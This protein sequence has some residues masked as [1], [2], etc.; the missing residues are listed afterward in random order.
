M[1]I[2]SFLSIIY[3]MPKLS[4]KPFKKTSD[5]KRKLHT[6]LKSPLA[7]SVDWRTRILE[8]EIK[9]RIVAVKEAAQRNA[10]ESVPDLIKALVQENRENSLNFEHETFEHEIRIAITN[11]RHSKEHLQL[12]CMMCK[13]ADNDERQVGAFVIGQWGEINCLELVIAGLEDKDSDV[14]LYSAEAIEY[15][16]KKGHNCQ[17]AKKSLFEARRRIGD[18]LLHE[19]IEDALVAIGVSRDEIAK[20]IKYVDLSI[21]TEQWGYAIMDL[22][23]GSLKSKVIKEL[24]KVN[25]QP[26][27]EALAEKIVDYML[28]H[29]E[30]NP[31]KAVQRFLNKDSEN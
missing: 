14:V 7:D 8:G 18:T 17:A 16:A 30:R 24:K 31:E 11:I 10:T 5:L 2:N 3:N 26:V 4:N 15:L 20:E 25:G 19:I 23:G 9:D 13:S 12:V 6:E 1:G 21:S 27:D 28:R 29:S 22:I